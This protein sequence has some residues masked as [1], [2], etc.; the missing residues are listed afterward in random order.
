MA[1]P[2]WPFWLALAVMAIGL[3]GVVLPGLP[4]LGLI[5]L[6]A[7]I[8]A[9]A[10]RFATVGPATLAGL[11]V[12]AG[13]GM[14]A[15][16][17]LG[18]AAGK[19]AGASWRA[20]LAGMIGGALGFGAGLF[21]GGIGA[22]PAGLIGALA[23]ILAVEYRRRRDLRAAMKA[24]AGWLAGCVI[25]RGLQFVIGLAMIGLFAWQAGWRGAP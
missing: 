23:G 15:D 25:G 2:D 24:G 9:L 3:A 13:L 8:Y 7:L 5:W 6:A 12:L 1:F 10:E 21:I 18:Q 4:G 17:L 11:T 16:F 20:L 19:A 14:A 22:L